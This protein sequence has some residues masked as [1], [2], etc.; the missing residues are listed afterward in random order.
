MPD[1]YAFTDT[2][3]FA[4][5]RAAFGAWILESRRRLAISQ[6]GLGAMVGLHQST[7]SRLERGLVAYLRFRTV[8][9]LL[10]TM[11]DVCTAPGPAWLRRL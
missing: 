10:V 9:R 4:A 8:M 2:P 7:I 5:E 6:A 11:L 1:W 3:Q